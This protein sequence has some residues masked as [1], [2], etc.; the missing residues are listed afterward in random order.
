MQLQD[1]NRDA[2]GYLLDMDAWNSDIAEQIAAEEGIELSEE[3]W[4]LINFERDF[5]SE[6]NTT[7][8]MRLLVKAIKQKYG[9][10][11]GNSRYLC[12][13]FPDGAAKQLAKISGLPKPV[14]CI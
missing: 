8:A 11:K 3:H 5:Y 13:L 7:P 6:F 10:E 4:E 12:R 9:E 1:L 14:K 2:E